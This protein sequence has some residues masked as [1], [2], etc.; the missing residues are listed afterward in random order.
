MSTSLRRIAAHSFATGV[1]E[2]GPCRIVDDSARLLGGAKLWSSAA[3]P[4]LVHALH[5]RVR[6]LDVGAFWKLYHFLFVE[7]DRR[8]R[9]G[10]GN[11]D[12]VIDD[13]R[14]SI[15]RLDGS[16]VLTAP[17]PLRVLAA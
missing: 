13:D 16:E 15:P 10:K 11:R 4:R 8:L 5:L 3:P 9:G 2:L 6:C 14:H 17:L 7:V 1:G 12:I